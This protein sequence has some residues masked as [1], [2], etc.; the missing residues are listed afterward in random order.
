MSLSNKNI[1]KSMTKLSRERKRSIL[2]H[3]KME[4]NPAYVRELSEFQGDSSVA[5]TWAYLNEKYTDSMTRNP[6]QPPT[7]Q[8]LSNNHNVLYDTNNN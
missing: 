5:E 4:E 6:N 1:S 8:Q 2:K 3:L 7:L